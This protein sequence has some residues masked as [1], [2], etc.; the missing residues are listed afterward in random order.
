[1]RMSHFDLKVVKSIFFNAINATIISLIYYE[2][3]STDSD[4][5]V[6]YSS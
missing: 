1:M 6:D 2:H 4:N 3:C 5:K